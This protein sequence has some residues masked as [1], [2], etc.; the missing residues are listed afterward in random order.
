MFVSASCVETVN[1]LTD[2]GKATVTW[3]RQFIAAE[4]DRVGL[5]APRG[6]TELYNIGKRFGTWANRTL[7]KELPRGQRLKFTSTTK[8]RAVASRDAFLGESC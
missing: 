5:L 7:S 6:H 8:Q 3:L 4:K 2:W 1:E